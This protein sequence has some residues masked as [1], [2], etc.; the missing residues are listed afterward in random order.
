MLAEALPGLV[1]GLSFGKSMRWNESGI[2]FSRPI[3]WYVALLG[4]VVL[5][6]EYAGVQSGRTT[7][8][9]R[10]FDSPEIEIAKAA[11]YGEAMIDNKIV[12]ECDL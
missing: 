6:F 1:A 4:E 9:L 10:L 5:P 12:V 3:R 7:R 11:V 2:V 8:G